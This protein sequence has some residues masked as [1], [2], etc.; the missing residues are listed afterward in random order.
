M[1]TEQSRLRGWPGWR[2]VLML[3]RCWWAKAAALSALAPL[4]AAALAAP[5]A[6]WPLRALLERHI[7]R[8]AGGPERVDSHLIA[9]QQQLLQSLAAAQGGA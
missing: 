6:T 5:R 3:V 1:A 8:Q 7:Q 4:V 9:R 2:L